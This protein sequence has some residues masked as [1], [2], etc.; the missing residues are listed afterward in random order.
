MRLRVR[1]AIIQRAAGN[2][3]WDHADYCS[4]HYD[5][6]VTRCITINE[7]QKET[8][9]ALAVQLLILQL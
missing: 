5:C 7:D 6:N 4:R 2:E 1:S 3:K 8:I 9:I